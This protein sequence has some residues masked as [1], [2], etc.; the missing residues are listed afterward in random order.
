MGDGKAGLRT[1]CAEP[2]ASSHQERSYISRNHVFAFAEKLTFGPPAP[3]TDTGTKRTPYWYP[4]P[5]TEQSRK[6]RTPL[7]RFP[8]PPFRQNTTSHTPILASHPANLTPPPQKTS[9][10]LPPPTNPIHP[11]NPIF[12]HEGRARTPVLLTAIPG[13]R[14]RPSQHGITRPA[15][16]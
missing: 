4:I 8:A 9:F 12:P 11:K 3:A 14:N 15:A 13:T 2:E 6:P 7:R 10:P 5:A 16:D 1:T